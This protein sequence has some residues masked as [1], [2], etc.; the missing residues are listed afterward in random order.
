V[1]RD[2]QAI[3]ERLFTGVMGPL[4]LGGALRPGP[5]IGA[6]RAMDLAGQLPAGQELAA[7]VGAVSAVRLRRARQLAPIDSVPEPDGHD[8]ALGACVHDI[9]Q[10]ANPNFDALFR[11]RAAERILDG[12][13]ETLRRI[14][15]AANVGVALYRHTWL[16]RVLEVG[17]TDT[18]VSWW[19][20]SRA[21]LGTEPPSR[22]QAWPRVRRVNVTRNRFGLLEL[23][24]IAV[25]RSR[26]VEAL[27]LLLKCTPLTDI[28]TC[29][30]EEPRFEWHAANLGLVATRSGRTLALRALA[31]LP[32]EAV[33]VALGR[34]MRDLLRGSSGSPTRNPVQLE[35]QPEPSLLRRGSDLAGEG[36]ATAVFA[37]L[38]ERALA[39]QVASTARLPSVSPDAIFARALGASAARRALLSQDV[40]WPRDQRTHFVEDLA[41]IAALCPQVESLFAPSAAHDLQDPLP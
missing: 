4:V 16:G 5:A 36:L 7:R 14:P 19:L 22:L 26:L 2:L 9:L 10:S 12:A 21:F 11:R 3:E 24:P 31:L 28:A 38:S 32:P 34:A 13:M 37:L 17:R 18:L 40:I 25:D 39:E 15:A 33:D 23:R 30:R 8:W 29:A 27:D 35:P 6:R 41:A 1:K 20:G